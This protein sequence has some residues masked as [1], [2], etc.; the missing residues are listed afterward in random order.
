MAEILNKKKIN[1]SIDAAEKLFLL[2]REKA[3]HEL[4]QIDLQ[5]KKSQFLE[6]SHMP[7]PWG[8]STAS[9]S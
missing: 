6:S 2:E 4:H 1:K 8:F 3:E 9:S 7:L 5:S